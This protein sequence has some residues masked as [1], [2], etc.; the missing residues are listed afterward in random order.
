MDEIILAKKNRIEEHERNLGNGTFFIFHP[1]IKE[2]LFTND[3]ILKILSSLKGINIP[4]ELSTV[5]K[6]QWVKY[7]AIEFLGYKRPDGLRTA[8]AKNI[9][10]NL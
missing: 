8:Q 3:E 5:E 7:K 4:I 6:S 10:Q 9:N 2:L 1:P